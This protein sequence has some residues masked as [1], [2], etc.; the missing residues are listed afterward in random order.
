MIKNGTQNAQFQ[1]KLAFIL[2]NINHKMT[3][4]KL[5]VIL[6]ENDMKNPK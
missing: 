4:C 1:I 5:I 3:G 6:P 2:Q